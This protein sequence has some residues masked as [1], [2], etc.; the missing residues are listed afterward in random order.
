MSARNANN[1]SHLSTAYHDRENDLLEM[2]G[3]LG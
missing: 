1:T 3:H 2:C